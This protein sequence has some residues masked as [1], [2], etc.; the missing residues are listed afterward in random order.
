VEV[1]YFRVYNR[2]GNIVFETT[3]NGILDNETGGWDGTSKGK[4][5]PIGVYAYAFK[6]LTDSGDT[7]IQSG[8]I[9]LLR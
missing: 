2:W 9:T 3:G 6:G 4:E 5:Q 1:D 7:I 8:N